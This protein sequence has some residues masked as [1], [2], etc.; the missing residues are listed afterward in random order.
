MS[1]VT[2]WPDKPRLPQA[3][4]KNKGIAFKR[5]VIVH[6]PPVLGDTEAMSRIAGEINF[7]LLPKKVRRFHLLNTFLVILRTETLTC[8]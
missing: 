7:E 6:S 8:S 1:G 4:S 5:K 3:S 2:P